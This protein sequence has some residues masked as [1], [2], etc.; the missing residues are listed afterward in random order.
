MSVLRRAGGVVLSE[1]MAFLAADDRG[2]S[3]RLSGGERFSR[4]MTR[5][6][7]ASFDAFIVARAAAG[8][9]GGRSNGSPMRRRTR[10]GGSSSIHRWISGSEID[11]QEALRRS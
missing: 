6:Q 4:N 8:D 10:R 2:S 9:G 3:S 1:R 11:T 7:S 5:K